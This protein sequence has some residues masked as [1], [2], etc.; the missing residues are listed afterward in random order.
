[1]WLWRFLIIPR[2]PKL[3][4]VATLPSTTL[5]NVAGILVSSFPA[6]ATKFDHKSSVCLTDDSLEPGASIKLTLFLK[7][8]DDHPRPSAKALRSGDIILARRVEPGVWNGKPV[9]TL[10]AVKEN[11]SYVVVDGQQGMPTDGVLA[12]E[13]EKINELRDWRAAQLTEPWLVNL[14]RDGPFVVRAYPPVRIT[15]PQPPL[16]AEQPSDTLQP[17]ALSNDEKILRMEMKGRSKLSDLELP[18]HTKGYD[19][20]LAV[21]RITSN[22]MSGS[23]LFVV[24]WDGSGKSLH[25]SC[26]ADKVPMVAA[27]FSTSAVVYARI[28]KARV[29]EDKKRPGELEV[30]INEGSSLEFLDASDREVIEAG[31][32]SNHQQPQQPQPQNWKCSACSFVNFPSR[33]SCHNTGCRK[34][35]V[36]GVD[37]L[38]PTPQSTVAP[39]APPPIDDDDNGE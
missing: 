5:V 15:A 1:L 9:L 21:V 39:N 31:L 27:A 26:W 20:D 14:N 37:Q 6:E 25:G 10:K 24:L 22:G 7:H 8:Q 19:C 34:A 30:K 16:P 3:A 17:R 4:Q 28:T 11:P 32:L 13:L 35:F 38:M 12:A 36:M 2:F 23:I 33:R 18:T 29:I